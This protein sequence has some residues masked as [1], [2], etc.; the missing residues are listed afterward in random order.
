MESL[1]VGVVCSGL[2][3]AGLFFTAVRARGRGRRW[4]LRMLGLSLLPFALWATGIARL[5]WRLL[6]ASVDF[7]ADLVFN[8][9]IWAGFGALAL[10]ALLLLLSLRRPR[11]QAETAGRPPAAPTA[12]R[13]AVRQQRSSY[14]EDIEGMDEIEEILR[15]RGIS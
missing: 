1:V 8:P 5:L 9:L 10:S 15:R 4:T 12:D 3:A 7:F 11:Q 6:D 13:R 2:T 14:D